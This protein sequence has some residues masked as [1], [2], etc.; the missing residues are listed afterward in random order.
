MIVFTFHMDLE[1]NLPS[2][3]RCLGLFYWRSLVLNMFLRQSAFRS[4][5]SE[6]DMSLSGQCSIHAPPQRALALWAQALPHIGIFCHIFAFSFP[7]SSARLSALVS[8]CSHSP[9]ATK[10]TNLCKPSLCS[11]KRMPFSVCK[12][13]Q[14]D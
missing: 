10:Y 12:V 13:E 4:W 11:V 14:L 1:H 8:S 5:L 2:K 9:S 7:D 3:P 6:L